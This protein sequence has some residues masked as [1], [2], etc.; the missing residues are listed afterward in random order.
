MRGTTLVLLLVLL[1]TI[2][3][4]G[5]VLAGPWLDT[6]HPL[7]SGGI[8]ILAGVWAQLTAYYIW[9]RCL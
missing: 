8:G 2:A 6:L 1:Y 3:F 7:L 9:S 4:T 5:A